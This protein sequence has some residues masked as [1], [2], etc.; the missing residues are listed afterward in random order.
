MRDKIPIIVPQGFEEHAVSEN[1][2]AGN[3]MGRR[4]GYQYGTIL[5]KGPKGSMAMGIGLGQSTGTVSYISPS[6][7]IKETRRNQDC[8]RRCHGIS[9][10]P[11]HRSA[12]GNEHLVR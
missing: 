2:Y 4:A 7:E 8:R 12:G 10:D 11:W 6:D 9:D 3:A 5:D 1:V